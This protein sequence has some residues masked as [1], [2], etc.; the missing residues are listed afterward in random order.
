MAIQTLHQESNTYFYVH[1]ITPS[2]PLPK[3][4]GQDYERQ[5]PTTTHGWQQA[6][7]DGCSWHW[8]VVEAVLWCH[9]LQF[10]Q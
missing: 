7:S 8:A 5:Q 3:K 4:L 2:S 10:T 9:I 1:L 6:S